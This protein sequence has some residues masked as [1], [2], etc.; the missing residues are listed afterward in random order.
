[1][2]KYE[3]KTIKKQYLRVSMFHRKYTNYFHNITVQAKVRNKENKL[4]YQHI[5]M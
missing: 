2:Q 5:L 4:K 1:M 3:R